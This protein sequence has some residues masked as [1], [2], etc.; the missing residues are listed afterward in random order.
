MLLILSAALL[1]FQCSAGSDH[2]T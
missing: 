2:R 1:L